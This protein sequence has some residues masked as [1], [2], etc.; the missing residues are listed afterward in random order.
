MK[1]TVCNPV[2]SASNGLYICLTCRRVYRE[3]RLIG[4]NV[5]FEE[6][7]CIKKREAVKR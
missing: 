4:G 7:E 1:H 5:R 6:I 2:R 3:V